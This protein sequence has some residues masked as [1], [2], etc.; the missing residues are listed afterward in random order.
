VT[1]FDSKAAESHTV[2]REAAAATCLLC[3][4]I[5]YEHLYKPNSQKPTQQCAAQVYTL[6]MQSCVAVNTMRWSTTGMPI[7]EPDQASSA[8]H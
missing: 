5:N 8:M 1:A 3:R 7:D 6:S 2:L 4:E